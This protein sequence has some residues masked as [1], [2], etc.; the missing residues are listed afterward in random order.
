MNPV[1]TD[2]H[3]VSNDSVSSASVAPLSNFL[4]VRLGV[5]LKNFRRIIPG[6]QQNG[7]FCVRLFSKRKELLRSDRSGGTDRPEKSEKRSAV[8]GAITVQL[9]PSL[10]SRVLLRG[11]A[12][13]VPSSAMA[14]EDRPALGVGGSFFGSVRAFIK[15]GAT[16]G[17]A[18]SD[19]RNPRRVFMGAILPRVFAC[20]LLLLLCAIPVYGQS[21]Y[22]TSRIT[23]YSGLGFDLGTTEVILKSGGRELNPVLGQSPYRRVGVAIGSTVVVDVATKW[24]R[25]NGH[26]RAATVINFVFGSVHI[27]AGVH[28]IRGIRP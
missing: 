26:P 18:I 9:M 16:T 17:A 24:L 1:K 6:F 21:A 12:T 2:R 28:N 22:T 5:D 4:G 27:G 14:R 15:T 20:C 19:W 7:G 3:G 13:C 25:K 10:E 8:H 11:I 23:L